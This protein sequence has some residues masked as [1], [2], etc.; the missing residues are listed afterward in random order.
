EGAQVEFRVLDALK[1]DTLPERFDVITCTQTLHHFSPDFVAEFLFQARKSARRG[2]L[3]FDARRAPLTL[4][5]TSAATF[6]LTGNPM[7]VHDGA[8][9]VRR[10]YAPAELEMLAH[11]SPGG[12][13]FS[14]RSFGLVYVVLKARTG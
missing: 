13:V 14:A 1:L 12:E 11:V 9:S 6:L 10:M 4:A 3:V 2:V 8:V 5:G 7:L